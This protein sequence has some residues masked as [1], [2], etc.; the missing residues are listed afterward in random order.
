MGNGALFNKDI[1]TQNNIE[2]EMEDSKSETLYRD[3]FLAASDP[4]FLIEKDTGFLLKVNN[5]ACTE[6]GY[7]QNELLKLRNTDL[8]AE[9]NLTKD[10][11]LNF[12]KLIPFRY[13]RRKDGTIF[14]VEITASEFVFNNRKVILASIRDISARIALED[15]VKKNKQQFEFMFENNNAIMLLIEVT[16]GKII[17]ANITA[18][19]FYGYSIDELK[20]MFIEQINT[21]SSQKIRSKMAEALSRENSSFQFNHMLRNGEIRTVEV[22]SS[23]FEYQNTTILFSTIYDITQ[24]RQ[25]QEENEYLS[26]HDQLTGL[27]NRRFYQEE[28]NRMDN[29][30]NYPLTIAIGDINGLK[31]VND[32]FGHAMGDE[33]LIKAANI[34]KMG[35]REGDIVARLGGDEFVILLP[36]TDEIEGERIIAR[37]IELSGSTKIGAMDLSITFGHDTKTNDGEYLREVF[38]KAEDLMYKHKLYEGL[39]M[40]SK[41]I[42]LILNTLYEKNGREMPHSKRVSELCE[43]LAIKMDFDKDS[44]N[45]MR[46]AGLMHDIGRIGIDDTILNKPGKLTKEEWQEIER[47]SE[48]GYRILSSTTQF[49]DI[50][51]FILE[52]HERWDGSG[53]PK[54]LKGDKICLQAR[55]IAI[56]DA[57]DAMTSE[58]SYDKTFSKDEAIEEMHMCSGTQFD[59]EIA[60]VFIDMISG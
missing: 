35:C 57:F 56:A 48:I 29:S 33:L 2:L 27:Y 12:E 17:N 34:I 16:S 55:M 47:H 50:A 51:G 22:H 32:S 41:T 3:I 46:V 36:H 14:P 18:A 43:E 25:S 10:K 11:T 20:G 24:I 38:K 6:Y 60:K 59:P 26:Y 52:H 39:S 8:S 53:Y 37:I 42:D 4:L 45:Q 28:M 49:L 31:L 9:P 1:N 5:S 44:V 40:K 54:G 7:A 15:A 30:R 13:H 21:L 58:R 19:E 23:P